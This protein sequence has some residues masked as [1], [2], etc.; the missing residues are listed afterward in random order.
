MVIVLLSGSPRQ[1]KT[2]Q[3]FRT[4]VPE[5]IYFVSKLYAGQ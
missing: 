5:K 3:I 1:G 4:I 2:R